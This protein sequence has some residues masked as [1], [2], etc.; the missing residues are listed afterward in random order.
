VQQAVNAPLFDLSNTAKQA[1]D[2]STYYNDK[3]RQEAFS[4]VMS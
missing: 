1:Q 2:T 3:A 4:D